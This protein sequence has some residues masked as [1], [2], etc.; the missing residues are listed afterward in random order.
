MSKIFLSVWYICFIHL[1]TW[2][3][4]PPHIMGCPFKTP[5]APARTEVGNVPLFEHVVGEFKSMTRLGLKELGW[6]PV[7]TSM[8]CSEI[9]IC[10]K[11][12]K[13]EKYFFFNLV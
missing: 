5:P 11:S 8:T 9:Q 4:T 2:P 13:P 12:E 6:A 10:I 3:I 1:L 7:A